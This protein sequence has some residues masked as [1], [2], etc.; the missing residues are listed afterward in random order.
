MWMYWCKLSLTP[1][2]NL[3]QNPFDF[4]PCGKELFALR[5]CSFIQIILNAKQVY[6]AKSLVKELADN[7]DLCVLLKWNFKPHSKY[8]SNKKCSLE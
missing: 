8:Q 1:F 3:L 6:W 4:T 2:Y 7:D 5:I